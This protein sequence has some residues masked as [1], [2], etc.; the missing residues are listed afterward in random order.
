M[1]M[2]GTPLIRRSWSRSHEIA[3]ESSTTSERPADVAEGRRQGRASPFDGP[4]IAEAH[5]GGPAQ[6][7]TPRQGG[8][9]SRSLAPSGPRTPQVRPRSPPALSQATSPRS[10]R[11]RPRT[12]RRTRDNLSATLRDPRRRVGAAPRQ[13][14]RPSHVTY[15]TPGGRVV[16]RPAMAVETTAAAHPDKTSRAWSAALRGKSWARWV[17]RAALTVAAPGYKSPVWTAFSARS[18]GHEARRSRSRQVV[19]DHCWDV[20]S[21]AW[22]IDHPYGSAVLTRLFPLVTR[23]VLSRLK[24]VSG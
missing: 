4:A 10:P 24:L 11:G 7:G 18:S 1:S 12:G 20:H 19:V 23:P 13:L 6:A 2:P 8:G 14:P 21:P 3:E 17:T 5:G 15:A 9:R 22:T 16:D